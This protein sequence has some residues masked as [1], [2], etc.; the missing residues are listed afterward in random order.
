[1]D[2]LWHEFAMRWLEGGPNRAA[3]Q[4]DVLLI[5]SETFAGNVGCPRA[6]ELR[7]LTGAVADV[8]SPAPAATPGVPVLPAWPR[9]IRSRKARC[10]GEGKMRVS[11][12]WKVVAM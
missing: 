6:V 11:S 4:N 12:A 1:M 3:D 7:L 10:I 9:V 2:N 5:N 8:Q